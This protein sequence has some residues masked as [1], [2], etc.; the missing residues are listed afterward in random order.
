MS[1]YSKVS[2]SFLILCDVVAQPRHDL[3]VNTHDVA[4]CLWT[5]K[6]GSQMS[7]VMLR[8]YCHEASAGKLGIVAMQAAF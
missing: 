2:Q 7:D 3:V 4:I 1:H 5:T 8:A 6:N